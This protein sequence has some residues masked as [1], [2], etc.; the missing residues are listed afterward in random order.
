MILRKQL[1]KGLI[2]YRYES[3]Q[4]GL[5]FFNLNS[6]TTAGILWTGQDY[7]AFEGLVKVLE[8]NQIKWTDLCFT[9]N[10]HMPQTVNA[11]SKKDFSLTRKPKSAL[12]LSFIN[13]KFDLFFDISLS[14][15]SY[16]QVIR[17]LSKASLK[18][19]WSDA[20]PDFFDFRLDVSKCPEPFFLVEQL[21]HY[22][23]EIKTKEA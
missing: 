18:A 4:R 22:L 11:I 15:S 21:T 9:D 20:V 5:K 8:Q 19:G 12:I 16:A 14:S 1:A 2:R 13:A 23:S 3:V 17:R 7:T 10:K 6:A